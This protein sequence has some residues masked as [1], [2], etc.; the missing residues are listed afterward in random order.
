MYM[1]RD[2][3]RKVGN[4]TS[5][6]LITHHTTTTYAEWRYISI[7]AL[8]ESEC[9]PPAA[10]S[11]GKYPSCPVNKRFFCA[12]EPLSTLLGREELVAPARNGAAIPQS[13][14]PYPSSYI[15]LDIIILYI[16]FYDCDMESLLWRKNKNCSCCK[17]HVQSQSLEIDA[18]KWNSWLMEHSYTYL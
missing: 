9:L 13:S 10:G 5:L 8:N 3:E 15:I 14:R 7:L 2:G 1:L 16:I 17:I 11:Q 18:T 12:P 4:V 6:C